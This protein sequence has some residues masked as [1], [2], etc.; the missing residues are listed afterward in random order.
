M[1]EVPV[2][3]LDG[4]IRSLEQIRKGLV[5]YARHIDQQHALQLVNDWLK[6]LRR[7]KAALR[8]ARREEGR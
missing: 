7:K 3:V 1:A 4:D 8:S 2:E 5:D 6:E